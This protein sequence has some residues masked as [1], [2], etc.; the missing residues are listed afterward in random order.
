MEHM[1]HY[2]LMR[3]TVIFLKVTTQVTI[4]ALLYYVVNWD[5]FTHNYRGIFH[6]SELRTLAL[7]LIKLRSVQVFHNIFL[8]FCTDTEIQS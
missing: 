1:I 2:L 4:K 8:Y 5:I 7:S 3:N 6:T